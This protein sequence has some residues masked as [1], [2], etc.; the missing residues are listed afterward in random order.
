V[1]TR[2]VL[3]G[4]GNIPESGDAVNDRWRIL[5]SKSKHFGCM[6]LEL[7]RSNLAGRAISRVAILARARAICAQESDSSR[8][9]L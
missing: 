6:V 7:H 3:P 2:Q 9:R 1:V 4:S 5:G 8:K